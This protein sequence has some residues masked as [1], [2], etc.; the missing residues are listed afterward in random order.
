MLG[1][2]DEND[3]DADDNEDYEDDEREELDDG[4]LSDALAK[5]AAIH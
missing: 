5:Q 3:E 1:S 4:G 2:M